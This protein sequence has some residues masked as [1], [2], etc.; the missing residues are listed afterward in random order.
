MDLW[1]LITPHSQIHRLG[2]NFTISCYWVPCAGGSAYNS[3]VSATF[4]CYDS[5]GNH[6]VMNAPVTTFTQYSNGKMLLNF[7]MLTGPNLFIT[8]ADTYRYLF[9]VKVSDNTSTIFEQTGIIETNP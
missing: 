9:T 7:K 8:Y 6:I 5:T 4:D 2:E 3:F 1:G